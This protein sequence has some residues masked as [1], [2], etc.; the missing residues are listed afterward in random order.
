MIMGLCRPQ[1]ERTRGQ[2][3]PVIL[4]IMVLITIM[5]AG[6]LWHYI[7]TPP[8]TAPPPPP[9]KYAFDI[10]NPFSCEDNLCGS[11]DDLCL[12]ISNRGADPISI[13]DL[14][15]MSITLI[16][17]NSAKQ[18]I[19]LPYEL[20]V[21]F[22]DEPV[23]AEG[24]EYPLCCNVTDTEVVRT[25]RCGNHTGV[26]SNKRITLAFNSTSFDEYSAE[27]YNVIFAG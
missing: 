3:M 27:R 12:T 17:G 5:M 19:I 20:Y 2:S 16:S 18:R 24:N 11:E 23:E 9:L 8:G 13:R 15:R 21:Y 25:S 26:W 10:V 4:V 6:L 1:G 7:S 22:P 14:S